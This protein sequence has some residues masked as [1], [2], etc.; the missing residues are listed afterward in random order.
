MVSEWNYIGVDADPPG[1]KL[2]LLNQ[3]GQPIIGTK[4]TQGVIAWAPMLQRH[5]LKEQCQALMQGLPE[6]KLVR[7]ICR[8]PELRD[9][10]YLA[11]RHYDGTLP[12]LVDLV[13]TLGIKARE[14]K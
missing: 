13:K 1:G 3:G 4:N 2:L 10:L 14:T 11:L 6:L 12:V 7:D 5:S 9:E 8:V